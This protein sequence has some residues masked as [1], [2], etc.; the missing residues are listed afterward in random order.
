MIASSPEDLRLDKEQLDQL[1]RCLRSAVPSLSTVDFDAFVFRVRRAMCAFLTDKLQYQMTAREMHDAVR[2][3]WILANDPDPAI[4][5]IRRRI[6]ESPEQ[7]IRR[8]EYLAPQVLPKLYDRGVSSSR[9]IG[10]QSSMPP[11]DVERLHE[12]GFRAWAEKADADMLVRAIMALLP[13]TGVEM[14]PGRSRG[15]GKRSSPR[16]EPCIDGI[17]RGRDNRTPSGGRPSDLDFKLTLIG[18]LAHAWER[19]AG[20][21]PSFGRSDGTA[22]GDLVHSIFQ[23][24]EIEKGGVEHALRQFRNVVPPEL[25]SSSATP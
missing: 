24:L 6:R 12:G 9:A 14:V 4:G 1:E 16:I 11:A 15:S 18:T 3:L 2:D 8:L 10:D 13:V 23:W 7:L 22:F 19:F 5:L 20:A 25:N 17:V 21:F